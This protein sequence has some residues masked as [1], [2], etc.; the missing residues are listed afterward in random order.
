MASR[1]TKNAH[2]GKVAIVVARP[3]AIPLCVVFV[4]ES[5]HQTESPSL[6]KP[7][8]IPNVPHPPVSYHTLLGTSGDSRAHSTPS[9]LRTQH[10]KH[11]TKANLEYSAAFFRFFIHLATHTYRKRSKPRT[12]SP[13]FVRIN[14]RIPRAL[15]AMHPHHYSH[16][17]DML[18]GTAQPQ[19]S[20]AP[21]MAP[22]YPRP[23]PRSTSDQVGDFGTIV[24]ATS[25]ATPFTHGLDGVNQTANYLFVEVLVISFC[26]LCIATLLFRWLRMGNAH[27]RHLFTMSNVQ[28][29]RFWAQNQT[30]FWPRFK[31]HLLYAPLFRQRH[32][33]E[34]QLSS[35]V[36]IGTL[37]SRFHTLLLLSYV[38]CNVA[39]CLV[40]NWKEQNTTAVLAELR[41]RTGVLAALNLI[42]TILFAL[43]NNPLIWMLRISYD[44]F[45]LFHRWCARMVILEAIVHTCAWAANAS[46]AGGAHQIQVSLATSLS[47]RWGMVAT[48]ALVF[49]TFQSISPVRHAFYET[50][51]NVHRLMVLF[52]IIGVYLHIDKA[53][54]PQLPWTRLIVALWS[55][56]WLWRI[57]RIVYYNTSRRTGLTKVT[58][59]A[60]PAE[61]CRVTFELA[62]PWKFR[63]GSHVHAYIPALS[64]WSSHPFSV[65]WAEERA[66]TPSP[67]LTPVI[68]LE[69]LP[70]HSLPFANTAAARNSH[71]RRFSTQKG[72]QATA[73]PVVDLDNLPDS[74]KATHLSLVMRARTG[75]TRKLYDRAMA[76]ST[77]RIT[78]RGAIEG[79]YG[80]HESLSSY[81]TV[82]LFA[83][84]VGITHCV[85]YIKQLI[86]QRNAGACSTRRLLL[87][88]SVP[89]TEALEW[90]RPWMDQ[91][92]KID[93]RREILRVQLFVTKPRHRNE[94]VSNSGGVQMFPG[95][96]NPATLLQKEVAEREGAVGVVVCGPGAF[97]DSV[98]AAARDTVGIGS[99]DFV[100]EAFTY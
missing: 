93:G 79:P 94:I 8:A 49:I 96:C 24:N 71:V 57:Y 62:R 55:L 23:F 61:A 39:Y 29:Q 54:L 86:E 70:T 78:L 14:S 25:A 80:G 27:I 6:V 15:V 9:N 99:V 44:T 100:E 76:S 12:P 81:G 31:K 67:P 32:N 46:R 77:G 85:G 45:N 66:R 11:S 43:R 28:E 16:F 98:R 91:I 34:I 97:A 4:S 72:P 38:A 19:D 63:P 51:L 33:Q 5:V 88:W 95:R 52:T 69:K 22:R 37:P 90:V 84:G 47:Y 7:N 2:N 36:S 59:E 48:C 58:V 18:A 30:K 64:L 1:A 42:P 10:S 65:A 53:N 92:L 21:Q 56:E 13:L 35:A 75:M 26:G 17:H 60:L 20:A 74:A 73:V 82:V 89:N 68:E 41:G 83:G 50:F 87:V 3:P 40:L